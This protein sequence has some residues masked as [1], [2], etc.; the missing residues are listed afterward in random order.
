MRAVVKK[1]AEIA[2]IHKK[3]KA[4]NAQKYNTRA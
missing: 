3:E 2:H 4:N 1:R